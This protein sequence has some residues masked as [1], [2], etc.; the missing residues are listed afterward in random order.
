MST[1]GEQQQDSVS[2]PVLDCGG[3]TGDIYSQED[4]REQVDVL[5]GE[6]AGHFLRVAV[7]CVE[8]PGEAEAE[9]GSQE[10]HPEHHL[11]LQRCHEVHVGPQHG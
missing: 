4:R 6:G 1:A 11:L 2:V 5:L 9:H 8:K 10:E 7:D 3:Q